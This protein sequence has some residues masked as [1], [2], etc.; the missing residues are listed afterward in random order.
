MKAKDHYFPGIEGE[1][2]DKGFYFPYIV[3]ITEVIGWQR[4]IEHNFL[5]LIR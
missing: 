3:S 1:V 2:C 5:L 4:K